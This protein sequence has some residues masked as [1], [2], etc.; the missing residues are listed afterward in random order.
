MLGERQEFAESKKEEK[1]RED[2]AIDTF[3]IFSP[4]D[5]EM[6]SE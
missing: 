6:F 1:K 5:Y 4:E 3:S 2:D